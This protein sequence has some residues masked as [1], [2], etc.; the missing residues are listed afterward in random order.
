MLLDSEQVSNSLTQYSHL[1]RKRLME[2]LHDTRTAWVSFNFD[3]CWHLDN[4]LTTS[5]AQP[6]ALDSKFEGLL[7]RTP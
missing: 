2:V 3:I 1:P 4:T 6:T 5:N 7:I